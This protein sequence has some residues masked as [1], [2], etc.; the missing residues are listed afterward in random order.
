MIIKSSENKNYKFLKSLLNKKYRTKEKLFLV[1]GIKVISESFEYFNPKYIAIS[2]SFYLKNQG[3]EIITTLKES[4]DFFFIFPDILFNKLSDTENSQGVIAYYTHIHKIGIST[5][6][7][8][9]YILLDDVKDPGNVGGIIR[10]ADA[11][12]I[13]GVILTRECVDLYNPKLIRSTMASIFRVNIYTI[14]EK[15]EILN[16][17]KKGFKIVST[18][19]EKSKSSYNYSFEKNSVF[20]VGNEASGVSEEMFKYSDENI[21]IPMSNKVDSLNVNVASSIIMYEMNRNE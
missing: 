11:F 5:V 19:I 8:G 10:S 14:D 17:R 13:D 2:E 20:I 3:K 21:H 1:E 9:R 7:E 4:T 15:S 16:L 18:S 6:K 12:L